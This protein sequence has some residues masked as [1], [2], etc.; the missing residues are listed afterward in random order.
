MNPMFVF[1]VIF[2]AVALWFILSGLFKIVGG[3]ASDIYD[4]TKRAMK[5]EETNEE[6]FVN[7]FKESLKKGVKE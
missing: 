2:C 4:N 6:A 3:F 1:L 7:G 5:D